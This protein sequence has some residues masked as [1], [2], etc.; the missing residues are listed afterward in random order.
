[1]ARARHGEL[2]GLAEVKLRCHKPN[3]LCADTLQLAETLAAAL[4]S[5]HVPT[6]W[7]NTWGGWGGRIKKYMVIIH[8][9]LEE[10]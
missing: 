8:S 2:L 10:A 7:R 5:L 6:S 3:T 4:A 1:M 9:T